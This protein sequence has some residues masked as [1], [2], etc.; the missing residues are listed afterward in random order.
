MH[1]PERYGTPVGMVSFDDDSVIPP[2]CRAKLASLYDVRLITQ[3]KLN[4]RGFGLKEIGRLSTFTC[5]NNAVWP[6]L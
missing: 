4:A 6:Q 2:K 5:R 1:L 3:R